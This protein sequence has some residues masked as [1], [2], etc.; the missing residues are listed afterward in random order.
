MIPQPSF[1]CALVATLLSTPLAH[2]QEDT[3][4]TAP[5]TPGFKMPLRAT[6]PPF[7]E[8]I[9]MV[10][11]TDIVPVAH[12]DRVQVFEPGF[13]GL[14]LFAEHFGGPSSGIVV[15][16]ATGSLSYLPLSDK[17]IRNRV[18]NDVVFF[19]C[20]RSDVVQR[21]GASP[22]LPL[23][24]IHNYDVTVLVGENN[25]VKELTLRFPSG[26]AIPLPIDTKSS[27]EDGSV[28]FDVPTF[29]P[30]VASGK[31]SDALPGA[32]GQITVSWRRGTKWIF[33]PNASGSRYFLRELND[34]SLNYD[35]KERLET[36]TQDNRV[37]L[38]YAYDAQ[39]GMLESVTDSLGVAVSYLYQTP[40]E[41]AKMG[42][43]P[44]LTG[45][46]QPHPTGQKPAALLWQAF[47][48]VSSGTDNKPYLSTI[49]VPSPSG[50]GG[51]TTATLSYKDGYV[52]QQVDA[53]GN[54][55]IYTYDADGA[56]VDV[57]GK[58]GKIVSTW[59]QHI[60]SQGR[61]RGKTDAKGNHSSVD[62][63]DTKPAN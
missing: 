57:Q 12:A 11:P 61:N 35:E 36:V 55:R 9:D 6:V 34:L 1:L 23:G 8:E 39:S 53:N 42:T 33:R 59:F 14:P 45:V 22:G 51:Y 4:A 50:G 48:Y 32:W 60:D 26:V 18:G 46:T 56:R 24:W 20:F 63:G 43:A 31:A 52:G 27:S 25:G 19:R 13:G 29:Y 2:A 21:G 30:F 38:S 44:C 10:H 15:N 5:V 37:L 3:S 28:P 58:D 16:L 7:V 62:Y 49:S 47:G 54:Q 17:K 41:G 40:P